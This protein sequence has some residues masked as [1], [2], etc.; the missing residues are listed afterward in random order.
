MNLLE[1]S[2]KYYVSIKENDPTCN[3]SRI[4][5]VHATLVSMNTGGEVVVCIVKIVSPHNRNDNR[6]LLGAI[7]KVS[8]KACEP[9]A[10]ENFNIGDRVRSLL[11]NKNSYFTVEGFE[12]GNNRVICN[13]TYRSIRDR[14]RYA[15]RVHELQRCY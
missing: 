11:G 10:T 4:I 8:E 1:L 13:P 12:I 7:R 9:I 6:K 5:G 14:E 15:Y 2:K 3:K